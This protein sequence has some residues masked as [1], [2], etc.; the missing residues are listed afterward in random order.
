MVLNVHQ[1]PYINFACYDLKKSKI[2]AASKI[3]D[4]LNSMIVNG[5]FYT[6]ITHRLS[7]QLLFLT[8]IS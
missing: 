6:R 2:T 5:F 4:L 1:S 7:S 8:K 3:K